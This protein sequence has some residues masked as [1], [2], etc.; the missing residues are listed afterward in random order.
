MKTQLKA[1]EN[2]AEH[3]EIVTVL[4]ATER[5]ILK[6]YLH[7]Y[8][9]RLMGVHK[10]TCPERDT[11]SEMSKCSLRSV[12]SFIKKFDNCIIKK[13]NRW[14]QDKGRHD[15]NMYDFNQDFMEHMVLL[16]ETGY[17][18]KLIR[19]RGNDLK[20]VKIELGKKYEQDR[21]FLHEILYKRKGFIDNEIAQG[22][23]AKLHTTEFFLIHKFFRHKVLQEVPVMNRKKEY[24]Y[25]IKDPGCTILANLPLSKQEMIRIEQNF[26]PKHIKKA[27]EAFIFKN[28]GSGKVDNPASFIW[29]VCRRS[30]NETLRRK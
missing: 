10:I 21:W 14:N 26:G 23:Y 29:G 22:F 11:V 18:G 1:P 2:L 12:A 19:L 5:K 24:G 17:L 6:T 4:T 25:G 28:G 7:F 27:K 8:R 30:M 20:E 13:K 15:P 9:K 16:Q 3:L